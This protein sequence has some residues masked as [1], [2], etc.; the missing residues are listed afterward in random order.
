VQIAILL[1]DRFTL[2][3]AVGPYE[4]LARLPEVR[5]QF[6]AARPGLVRVDTGLTGLLAEATLDEAPRPD[7]VVVPGG[8]GTPAAIQEAAHVAWLRAVHPTTRWTTSVCTGAF[9]L[10]AAGLLQGAPATTHWAS[11]NYLPQVGATYVPERV[12]RH[13]RVI[14]AAGVSAGIDMALTL[15]AE[16]AGAEWAQAAQLALE[17]DPQPPFDA[18]ALPKADADVIALSNRLLGIAP[19]A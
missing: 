9:L 12:V 6:V 2:L 10:G 7:V 4:V 1:Y 5:V 19:P 8:P 14:T 18:G 15:A 16:I 13:G 11:R 3:D 17:Y